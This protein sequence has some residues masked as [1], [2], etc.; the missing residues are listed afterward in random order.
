MQSLPSR[1]QQCYCITV[2]TVLV[3]CFV[4]VNTVLLCYCAYCVTVTVLVH[5]KVRVCRCLPSRDQQVG[6]SSVS[7][8]EHSPP[9]DHLS[10][11]TQVQIE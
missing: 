7:L 4:S 8:M 5:Q 1:D 9:Q 10:L 6:W 2:N 11:P 3:C